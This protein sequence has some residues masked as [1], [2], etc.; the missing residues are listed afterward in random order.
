MGFEVVL[1]GR[2]LPNS[3]PISRPYS[4]IRMK[5]LFSKGP[6]FY[7]EFNLRLFFLLLFTK[8]NVLH[9]NDLDTLLPNFIVSKLK[10]LPLVYDSHEYFTEVPEIQNKP[11]VKAIWKGI[12]G[13]IFPKLKRTLTVNEAIAQLFDNS[14]KNKPLVIRNVPNTMSL[15]SKM[16]RNSVGVP[17]DIQLV[18]IQG[19][20]LN[21]DRGVEEAVLAISLLHNVGLMLI[22]S[23]DA[24][25]EIKKMV[26]ENNLQNKVFFFPKM[27][28]FQMIQYT[29]MADL[30][31]SLDKDTNLNYRYSLPNKLFDYIHAGIPVLASDLVEV[32][33]IVKTWQVGDIISDLAPQTLAEKIKLMLNDYPKMAEYKANTKLAALELNWEKEAEEKL[34]HVYCGL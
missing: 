20:G 21:M 7:A 16:D 11:I 31:L 26:E 19:A 2:I 22:G 23:G 14:Y 5:L 6:F 1:V 29:Q 13:W 25:P 33:K 15:P 8:A 30:G 4:T 17:E 12:E 34:L 32:S 9:S 24:L 10:K 18:V 3:L 27:D 28:Y